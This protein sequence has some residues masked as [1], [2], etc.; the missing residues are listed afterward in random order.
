MQRNVEKMIR[1]ADK[2]GGFIGALLE[3]LNR[4]GSAV[5]C[6]LRAGRLDIIIINHYHLASSGTYLLGMDAAS[7]YLP[8]H[9][10]VPPM[11]LTLRAGYFA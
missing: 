9:F 6:R 10:A 2:S 3:H 8:C 5:L 7:P 4:T 1:H 11:V